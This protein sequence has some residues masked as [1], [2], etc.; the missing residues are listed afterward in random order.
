MNNQ[1]YWEKRQAQDMFEHMEEAEKASR[2]LQ[3][4]YQAA[5]KDIQDRAKKIF[6]AYQTRHGLSRQEAGRLLRKVKDPADVKRLLELLKEDPKNA[7]LV[8]ELES[9]AYGARIGQLSNLYGQLNAV[10]LSIYAE[11]RKRCRAFLS[12]LAEQAYYDALFNLQ[13]YAGYG[14][15]FK[16][17][18]RKRIEKVLNSKWSGINYS[19]R[20]W[21][22]TDKLAKAVK[23][24]IILNLLTGR[25]L[26]AASEA[27]SGQFDAGYNDARRLIRTESCFICNQ[28]QALSYED[29]GVERYIYVAVLDL[30]TSVTCRGLDK[31]DFPVA[32]ATPGKNY[33]PMHPWC[34]STTIAYMSQELL[35]KLK[36]SAIDPSTGKRILVPG[37]MTYQQWHDKFV[38]GKQVAESQEKAMKNTWTDREQFAKY[39]EIFGGEMPGTV[40]K[41]QDLKY[42]DLTGWEKLKAS[43]Q[44]RLNQMEF[45]EMGGLIGKLG[46]KETRLWYKARTKAITEQITGVEP[47]E[48]KARKAFEL[49]KEIRQNARALMKD[50]KARDELPDRNDSFEDLLAKKLRKHPDWSRDDA[51]RDIVRSSQASNPEYDKKAGI[52]NE[53]DNV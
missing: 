53:S 20:L 17:L 32:E 21:R 3:K 39:K 50:G 40:E 30:K 46:N 36:Q 11:Q 52:K 22:N 47:L 9:Q 4:L 41:F 33:P 37:D 42:N 23:R 49:R 31:K 51:L 10:A 18:D 5:S 14:F 16:L 44:E 8:K 26:K 27:I 45:S 35:R 34:R 38:K 2:E 43:K 7:E 25:P 24:E 13:Q 1:E 12:E 19:Q 29:S 6:G 28:M 15:D 48:A